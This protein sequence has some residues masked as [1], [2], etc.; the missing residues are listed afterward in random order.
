M[1]YLVI[2]LD[3]KDSGAKKR[4]Q[5]VRW[6]HIALWDKLLASWNMRYGAAILDD[7][8]EMKWSVLMMYFESDDDLQERLKKEPYVTGKV[9]KTIDIHQCNTRDPQQ[10]NRPKEFFEE[11]QK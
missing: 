2:G 4:R 11:R 7:D 10:F 1:Q 5:M 3:W 6:E 9:W 8:W